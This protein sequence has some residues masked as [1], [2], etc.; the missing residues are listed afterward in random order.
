MAPAFSLSADMPNHTPH[1]STPRVADLPLKGE[2]RTPEENARWT[3]S[4]SRST[5]STRA[6]RPGLLDRHPG[7]GRLP[8]SQHLHDAATGLIR[9]LRL[10]YRGSPLSGYDSEL[11]KARKHLEA[12][13]VYFDPGLNEELAATAVWGSQ[14]AGMFGK[15]NTTASIRF[16][17]ARIP[18]STAPA[19]R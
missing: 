18:G 10:G 5:T 14:Q 7:A 16:G 15:R 13:H 8:I 11:M 2:A 1:P 3:A 17:T 6:L 9:R 12:N 19:M 4:R